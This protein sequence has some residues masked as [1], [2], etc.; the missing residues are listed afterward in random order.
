VKSI[1]SDIT[2]VAHQSKAWRLTWR[3]TTWVFTKSLFVYD[4]VLKET[5]FAMWWG[6]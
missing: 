6:H 2:D 3:K 1:T 4:Y 5:S